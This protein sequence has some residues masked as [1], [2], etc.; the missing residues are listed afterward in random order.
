MASTRTL[1]LS[2]ISLFFMFV[3]G[4]GGGGGQ[5]PTPPVGDF[6]VGVSSQT[7][8]VPMGGSNG[9]QQVSIQ[10]VSGF[11][12]PVSVSLSGLPAGVTTSPALPV[13]VNP[14]S[15]QTVTLMAASGGSPSV[16]NISVSGSSGTLNH[17]ASFSLSVANPSF[18]YMATGYPNQ[19]PYD[20]VGYAVD[21][22]T[23]YLS[24][25]PGSPVSL[26]STASAL[27]V[28][29]ETGGSFVY[30][31][32][33]DSSTQTVSLI[34]YSVNASTGA[35]TP[36][37]TI[38]YSPSTSQNTLVVHP[39]GTFLYVAQNNCLFAYAID[40]AT[41]NLTQASCTANTDTSNFAV[42]A[43]GNFAYALDP[44]PS[45]TWYVY[46][47][48]PS[49]GSVTLLQSYQGSVAGG[50]IGDPQGRALYLLAGPLG[51]GGC[52]SFSAYGIDPTSGALTNLATTFMAPCIPDAIAFN[53][54][55]NLAYV[56]SGVGESNTQNGIY[57]ATIDATGNLIE[58]A[59]SP[60]ASGT[61][62]QY[63]AVELSQ[64]KFLIEDVTGSPNAQLLI[65][66]ID[67]TTGALTQVSGVQA[68][69]P[70]QYSAYISKMVTI[71]A[72]SQQGSPKNSSTAQ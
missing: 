14:G 50:L 19:P 44:A 67:T 42:P 15:P 12:Q 34:S 54:A 18:A 21:P 46:S 9:T 56:S 41:G 24:Q 26:S 30:T 47:V 1:Q 40:P 8:F 33:P 37:Q 49:D 31:L 29:T 45:P 35:L 39:L 70:S 5:I 52:G 20:L 64:G 59:G 61:G 51:P 16:Q 71:P 28:A 7:V 63:G 10:A 13:M 66:S 2:F 57:G 17:T 62:V 55:A 72:A 23:G 3:N 43:P 11:S 4:C 65:Y 58:I 48:S 69:L 6:T 32:V 36:L 68:T 27:A 60:F 38:N 53:P 22:N 25:V